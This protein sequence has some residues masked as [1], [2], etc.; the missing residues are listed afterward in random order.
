MLVI[1]ADGV[2]SLL[3]Q[4]LGFRNEIKRDSAALAVKEVIGLDEKIINERFNV[5][6]KEGVTIE[7]TGSFFNGEAMA[8][9]YTNKKS[10][11]LGVGMIVEDLVKNKIKWG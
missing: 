5:K 9:I 11:S 10:I 4:S 1:I 2:N 3:A 7:I 8:F 6:S